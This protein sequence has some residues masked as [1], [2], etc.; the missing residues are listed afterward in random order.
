MIKMKKAVSLLL[1]VIFVMS[2]STSVYANEV[3]STEQIPSSEYSSKIKSA[4]KSVLDFFEAIQKK[5]FY[6]LNRVSMNKLMSEDVLRNTIDMQHKKGMIAEKPPTIL[7]SEMYGEDMVMVKVSFVMAGK[8]SIMTYPVVLVNNEWIVN[9]GDAVDPSVVRLGDGIVPVIDSSTTNLKGAGRSYSVPYSGTLNIGL[10]YYV[11]FIYTTPT[12]IV[13][14]LA[15]VSEIAHKIG[16]NP[17]KIWQ[18]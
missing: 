4:E 9:V 6:T 2:L 8:E 3:K 12:N 16:N 17:T 15:V 5:D 11:P 13:S 10:S 7:S 18:R 1:M 14:V